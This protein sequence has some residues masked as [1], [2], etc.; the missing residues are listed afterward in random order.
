MNAVRCLGSLVLAVAVTSI[1][2]AESPHHADRPF[3]HF[4]F[5]TGLRVAAHELEEHHPRPHFEIEYRP[6]FH[7]EHYAHYLAPRPDLCGDLCGE[8]RSDL[9]VM[10]VVQRGESIRG[11]MRIEGCGERLTL[12]GHR[13][14]RR[15]EFQWYRNGE[16]FGTGCWS[17]D[18]H[19]YCLHG[20]MR[21]AV[22]G[23]G[24]EFNFE[25]L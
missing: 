20:D 23:N 5:D 10:H 7:H 18:D 4:A 25:R 14:D 16:S 24:R 3:L 17:I 19:G 1:S 8:W 15:V 6:E 21:N 22:H 12:V 2:Q 11:Q 9:G 13:V